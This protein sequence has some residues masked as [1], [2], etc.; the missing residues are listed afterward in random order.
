MLERA[1]WF[2]V[3]LAPGLLAACGPARA[4]P[5]PSLPRDETAVLQV[6]GT[7]TDVGQPGATRYMVSILRLDGKRFRGA[8][9]T[10]AV[11][12]GEHVLQLRWHKMQ[13]PYYLGMDVHAD[14]YHWRPIASGTVTLEV[15]AA[16]GMS[17]E[18]D[19]PDDG[20]DVPPGPPR[21]FVPIER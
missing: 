5:G 6:R 16:P 14:T 19:W 11:L 8:R 15:N 2:L 4:Y 20:P 3:L 17:Y 21:G 1:R 18:L 9:T 10:I 12:P 7:G 13:S